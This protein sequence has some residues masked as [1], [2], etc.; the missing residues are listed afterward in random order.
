MILRTTLGKQFQLLFP[1]AIGNDTIC[2]V[3]VRTHIA[4]RRKMAQNVTTT[5]EQQTMTSRAFIPSLGTILDPYVPFS[6]SEFKIYTI[7][8]WKNIYARL[9]A[10]IKNSISVSQIKMRVLK[11]IF[12]CFFLI[13]VVLLLLF[14]EK[15]S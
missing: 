3:S 4:E 10:F 2:L 11:F 8:G 7:Q 6:K 1:R 5:S 15:K 12:F 9:A 14:F 13:L